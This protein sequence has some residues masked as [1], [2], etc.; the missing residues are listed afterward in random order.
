MSRHNHSKDTPFSLLN[1]HF[2]ETISKHTA[3]FGH[4]DVVSHIILTSFKFRLQD[5][6]YFFLGYENLLGPKPE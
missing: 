6:S 1:V 3:V 4:S 2:E 5:Q